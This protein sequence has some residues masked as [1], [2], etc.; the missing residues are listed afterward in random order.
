MKNLT[1]FILESE[2]GKRLYD[3]IFNMTHN[4]IS[5]CNSSNI[6]GYTNNDID[7]YVLNAYN[8]KY[9]KF[10]DNVVNGLLSEYPEMDER[11]H[12]QLSKYIKHDN[13]ATCG[14]ETIGTAL[15]Q[16][17]VKYDYETIHNKKYEGHI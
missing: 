10:E 12:D 15:F 13:D 3:D 4:F 7:E 14:K 2:E 1:E 16:S 9:A 17:F 8:G 5:K 11:T 6:E